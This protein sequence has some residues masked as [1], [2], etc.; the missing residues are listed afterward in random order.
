[1][2]TSKKS[3]LCFL[4]EPLPYITVYIPAVKVYVTQLQSDVSC[5]QAYLSHFKERDSSAPKELSPDDNT[6]DTNRNGHRNQSNQWQIALLVKCFANM[7]SIPSILLN[8]MWWNMTVILMLQ[9]GGTEGSEGRQSHQVKLGSKAAFTGRVSL[10]LI[11]QGT[12][13]I[14]GN[15][16][17]HTA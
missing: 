7:Y 9:R 17:T 1:M 5:S 16:P 15:L 14:L 8:W 6:L 2:G 11:K 3:Y 13:P 12:N 4:H 10:L